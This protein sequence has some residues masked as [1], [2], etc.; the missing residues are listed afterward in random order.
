MGMRER[1]SF[2]VSRSMISTGFSTKCNVSST[3][4]SS[5]GTCKFCSTRHFLRFETWKFGWTLWRFLR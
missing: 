1:Q 2:L 5:R 4:R 3:C